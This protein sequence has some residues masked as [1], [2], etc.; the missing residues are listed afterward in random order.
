[1]ANTSSL[2]N[3]LTKTVGGIADSLSPASATYKVTTG[4]DGF[5][6]YT[7]ISFIATITGG[8]GGTLDAII[9]H[10][11]DGGTTWYEYV[12]LP[13]VAAA[14]AAS[15]TYGPAL[16]DSIV[17]VGKN[18]LAG[19]TLTT[20]MVLGNGAVAGSHWFDMLRVKY[21]AGASTTVGA[22]QVVRV[23]CVRESGSA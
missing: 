7:A 10:S 19:D 2:I 3:L 1:M 5:S 13:Q 6:S 21:V 4:V 15:Y 16:N 23:N 8:T 14:T 12:H 17:T 11:P 9:E 20:T 22:T 18:N